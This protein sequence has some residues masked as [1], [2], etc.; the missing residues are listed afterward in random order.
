MLFDLRD[1]NQLDMKLINKLKNKK[2]MAQVKS[3]RIPSKNDSKPQKD[4]SDGFIFSNDD[5]SFLGCAAIL[6]AA[7]PLKIVFFLCPSASWLL[8]PNQLLQ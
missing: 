8:Q 7:Q 6:A 1:T 3:L 4:F 5:Y 2:K